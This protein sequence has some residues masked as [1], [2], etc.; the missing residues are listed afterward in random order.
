LTGWPTRQRALPGSI[1]VKRDAT[2]AEVDDTSSASGGAFPGT[3]VGT[4]LVSGPGSTLTTANPNFAL[5]VGQSGTGTLTI[6]NG[7]VVKTDSLT[8]FGPQSTGGGTLNIGAAPGQPALAVAEIP[9]GTDYFATLGIPLLRGRLFSDADRSPATH[10]LVINENMAR[11][12][13]PDHEPVGTRV[14]TGEYNPKGDWYTIVGV[15]GNVKYEG[16][17]EKDQPTMY[18]PYFDSG[19]C[20]WFAREM[21][22][23]LRS[24]SSPEK[25]VSILQSA[26]WS[27]DNQLPLGHVRTMDQLM[28]DSVAS[29]RF[30]AIV[31]CIFAA[32]AL[33]LAMIGIYGVMAYAVSQR[34]HEIGIRVAL[35]AQRKN[36][37]G[38][39]LREGAGLAVLGVA[40]G[41]ASA[42]ALSRTLAGLI[43]GVRATDPGTF[44]TVAALLLGVALVGCYI[45]ARRAMRVDP[46]VA[47]RY[48]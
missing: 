26:A 4:V 45:P 12:Y 37:L 5:A 42:L 10:V 9:V 28:Y 41:S 40:L 17:G 39:V 24:A 36:I 1:S 11:R 8:L 35:G 29:S 13:F 32:L 18:V 16:L 14:Q 20:P 7:G 33:V 44:V 46:I 30:R 21:Y 38:T 15:V 2:I 22:V 31:F 3:N 19:W 25:V 6:Q 47:L 43:F 48:E 34:T 23:V 27:L